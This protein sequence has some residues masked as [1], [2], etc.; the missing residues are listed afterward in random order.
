MQLARAPLA[1]GDRR[2]RR[3]ARPGRAR[4]RAQRVL[5]RP[6]PAA[7]RRPPRAREQPHRRPRHRGRRRRPICRSSRTRSASAP[8][9]SSPS[10]ST[11]PC[12]TT[13]SSARRPARTVS[14]RYRDPARRRLQ[15]LGRPLPRRDRRRGASR[16]SGIDLD[17]FALLR[18]LA[19]ASAAGRGPTRRADGGRRGRDR[20][21]PDDARDLRRHD[22]PVHARARVGHRERRPRA[23]PRAQGDRRAGRR[24]PPR[25]LARARVEHAYA[26]GAGHG[27][28]SPPTSSRRE[29]QT[30]VRELVSSIRFYGSQEGA[31]PVRSLVVSGSLVDVPGFAARLGAD[32]GV[33]VTAADPFGRVETRRR[34]RAARRLGRRAASPS[35]SGSRTDMRAVN[36]LPPD[37]PVTAAAS[38]PRHEL[39]RKPGS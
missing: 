7:P 10:R 23:L 19:R 13:T 27:A 22:V 8:T 12:S 11:R 37:R 21:R 34:R 9:R 16:S 39:R 20:P 1:A 29:L 14:S 2:R 33:T 26:A 3:G 31:A 18:A 30:L 17:A 38:R 35:D 36:L 5:Q 24:A 28:S 6:R 4:D 25:R 32:L 15:R